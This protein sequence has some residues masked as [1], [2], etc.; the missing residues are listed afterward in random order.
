[1][2]NT[3]SRLTALLSTPTYPP[4]PGPYGY[5][6]PPPG[7]APYKAMS[8][9]SYSADERF[10]LVKELGDVLW[11]INALAI[12]LGVTLESVAQAN[13]EKLAGR[14]ER[15]TILSSGDNR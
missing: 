11:Y 7:Y 6:P 10:E 14:A 15:G 4:G 3:A 13:I 2:K 12:E 8:A 5:A 9:E 1:M